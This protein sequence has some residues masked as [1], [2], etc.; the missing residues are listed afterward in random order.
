MY[1]RGVAVDSAGNVYIADGESNTVDKVTPSGTLTVITG[2]G[3]HSPIT[4]PLPPGPASSF[5]NLVPYGLAVD[6]AGNLYIGDD[7]SY[8][9]LRVTPA[10]ILSVYAGTGSYGTPTSGAVA[11]S[12]PNGGPY[13]LAIDGAGNLYIADN[14]NELIEKVSPSGIL[15][16]VAGSTN[17]FPYPSSIPQPAT[18]VNFDR[19]YAV[20]VDYLGN[21]YIADYR[22]YSIDQVTPAG[23]IT[24]LTGNGGNPPYPTTTPASPPSAYS[25]G[26][27]EGVGVDSAGNVYISDASE[28]VVDRVNFY[29]APSA[30]TAATTQATTSTVQVNWSAG[31]GPTPSSYTVT[32]IVNGVPGTP[33]TVTGTSYSLPSGPAGTTYSFSIVANNTNG[34]SGSSV[35]NT[36]TVPA[37][38]PTPAAGSG[39]WTVGS[40]GGVFSFGPSY[41]GSTG[42]LK[43]NQPVFAITSTP[44]GKGYWF[45]AKDGGVFSYG[46]AVFHGSV[47]ALGVHVTNVVGM[48]ADTATGGYWLVGSDGSVYAFGAPFDGSIPG[49]HQHVTTI[50]GIAATADGGGYYLVSSTGAVYAFGDAKYQGGANTLLRLNAPIVA[51]SVDS[52]TGGYWLAGSDGGIYAYG[53]PFR[54]SAGGSPLN[55]PVVGISATTDGSGYYL[56]AS[57][58][59]VFSYNAPFLGSMGGK[60]LNAP[61]VGIT[62][63]G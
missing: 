11:T 2:A 38:P 32:P 19:V 46:D 29:Y 5:N 3:T 50:V 42:N 27:P 36:A 48:A 23:Q 62:V 33:V 8:D 7:S 44:D 24:V 18:S 52:A 30:P 58:G 49:L 59:G 57:D 16:I 9:V 20:A 25:V 45:V 31:V 22:N 14:G 15:T 1:A 60:H 39:Y 26:E 47:P 63:A 21:M 17:S 43:L 53:A 12:T 55:K 61:M 35:S 51:I 4:S 13:G 34:S 54:G 41:Y 37:A 28:D 6:S 40:D 56:V 10:G